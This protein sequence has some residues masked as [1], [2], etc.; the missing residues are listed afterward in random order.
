MRALAGQLAPF[1]RSLA[2]ARRST[3]CEYAPESSDHG[4]GQIRFKVPQSDV[5]VALLP[6]SK[7]L[8]YGQR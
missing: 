6:S 5:L 3:D 8:G 4:R 7:E 1:C 2:A